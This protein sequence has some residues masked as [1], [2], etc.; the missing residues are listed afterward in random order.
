MGLGD[1][2]VVHATL[3]K[4]TVIP[5]A[6]LEREAENNP[7]ELSQQEAAAVTWK[8]ITVIANKLPGLFCSRGS[9]EE[10][11]QQERWVWPAAQ[12]VGNRLGVFLLMFGSCVRQGVQCW[13]SSQPCWE[14]PV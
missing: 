3:P 13:G 9:A 8:E 4:D 1:W 7:A 14:L 12:L 6:N 5:A 2:D 11:R 10:K